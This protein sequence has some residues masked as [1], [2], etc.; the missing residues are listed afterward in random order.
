MNMV[1]RG[2]DGFLAITYGQEPS[3]PDKLTIGLAA[4]PV[5]VEMCYNKT[6]SC[7]FTWIPS[8]DLAGKNDYS[9]KPLKNNG[10]W[11]PNRVPFLCLSLLVSLTACL[12]HCVSL[13]LQ[14]M[15]IL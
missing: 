13:T 2:K 11:D 3:N 7:G 5:D 15:H 8:A 14:L 1:S 12:C 6:A 10:E 4:L 9:G